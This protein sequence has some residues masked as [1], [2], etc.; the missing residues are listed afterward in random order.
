MVNK[1]KSRRE[2]QFPV[3]E[4]RGYAKTNNGVLA[5]HR[6]YHDIDYMHKLS[7]EEKDWMGR[8]MNETL[9]TSF[10]NKDKDH[11][12]KEDM[13]ARLVLEQESRERRRCLYNDA[14][15]QNKLTSIYGSGR[16]GFRGTYADISDEL[17]GT[18][19]PEDALIDA[20]DRKSEQERITARTQNDNGS[21]VWPIRKKN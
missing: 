16:V 6:A 21:N 11:Y 19:S 4:Y 14:A 8:F 1:N 5:V 12:S 7:P 15:M 18:D 2:R 3:R 17:Y 10:E 9:Q 13:D 20:I